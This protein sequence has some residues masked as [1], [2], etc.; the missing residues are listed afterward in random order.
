[1]QEVSARFCVHEQ[2]ALS[3]CSRGLEKVRLFGDGG[4]GRQVREARPTIP[5][6]DEILGRAAL[7]RRCRATFSQRE[8]DWFFLFDRQSVPSGSRGQ[9]WLFDDNYTVDGGLASQ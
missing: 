6:I 8:K 5:H 7:I 9:S 1:M 2:P 3:D 4:A